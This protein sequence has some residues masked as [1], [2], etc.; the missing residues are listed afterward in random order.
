MMI[1]YGEYARCPNSHSQY[2]V[3]LH[4]WTDWQGS[5][6]QAEQVQAHQTMDTDI[7][8][9]HDEVCRPQ[10]IEATY[11]NKNGTYVDRS[12]ILAQ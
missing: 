10:L 7:V 1:C 12:L 4:P 2:V 6:Q 3:A 8:R 9:P 5:V 11:Q